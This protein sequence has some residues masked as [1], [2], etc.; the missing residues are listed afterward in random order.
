MALPRFATATSDE[1]VFSEDDR[2]SSLAEIDPSSSQLFT[3]YVEKDAIQ[4]TY[5]QLG[6]FVLQQLSNYK[7]LL[8]N[9]DSSG[10]NHSKWT[11]WSQWYKQHPV[12]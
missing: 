3:E 5:T 9:Q 1:E 8:L 2:L 12:V 10:Q 4:T 11:D 7:V 6:D